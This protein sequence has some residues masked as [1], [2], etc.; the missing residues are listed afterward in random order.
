MAYN[1]EKVK[2]REDPWGL[3]SFYFICVLGASYYQGGHIGWVGE[4]L[5]IE[6]PIP[7]ELP[8][9]T[10]LIRHFDQ[11]PVTFCEHVRPPA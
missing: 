9:K 7:N 8:R 2:S 4:V 3:G 6:K 11:V 5:I 1:E 10:R